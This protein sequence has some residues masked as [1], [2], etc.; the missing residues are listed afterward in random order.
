MEVR[1]EVGCA[2]T[3]PRHPCLGTATASGK[4]RR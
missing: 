4:R 1:E 2:S 3:H